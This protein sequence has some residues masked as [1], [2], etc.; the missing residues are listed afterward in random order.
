MKRA[1]L[2]QLIKEEINTALNENRMD[3]IER[4]IK[5]IINSSFVTN[6]SGDT[7]RFAPEDAIKL[8]VDLFRENIINSRPYNQQPPNSPNTD[9][10]IS[11][12]SRY[13]D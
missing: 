7:L 6:A 13:R 10:E 8:L 11:Y 3:G 9:D 4:Q 2:V 5:K 1:E 12:F